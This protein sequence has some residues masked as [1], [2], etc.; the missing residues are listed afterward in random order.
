MVLDIQLLKK[1]MAKIWETFLLLHQLQAV[2]NLQYLKKRITNTTKL[3]FQSRKPKK[4]EMG[5]KKIQSPQ[6]NT[7]KKEKTGD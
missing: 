4:K 6:G 5:D 1:K 2:N 7:G 3:M